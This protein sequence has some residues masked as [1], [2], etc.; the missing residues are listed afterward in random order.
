MANYIGPN[1]I[2][3]K[4][5]EYLCPP[6]FNHFYQNPPQ[7]VKGEMQYLYDEQGKKYLDFFAGVSVMN[8]GHCNPKILEA[9]IEQMKTLQ[10]TSIIYLTQPMVELAEKLATVLPGDLRRSFF[11][12]T[13]SEANETALLMAKMYTGKNEF[14]ALSNGLHG[15]TYMTMSTTAIPMWR[16]DPCLMENVHFAP[17]T[18]NLQ[19]GSEKAAE[20]SLAA[21][22]AIIKERGEDKIAALIMEPIQGNG[23][24]ITPPKNYFKK[25]KALLE[26]YH[27]LLIVDEVQTGF[28]RTGRMFA[29]E[30]YD[31]VPDIMTVAKALG[32]GMPISAACTNDKIAASFNKPS[33]STLGGNPVCAATA[34]AVLDYIQEN[35][36]MQRAK[37]LGNQL[38]EGLLTLKNKYPVI[39]DVRGMGLMVGVELRDGKGMALSQLTDDVLEALKDSGIIVG[40]NGLERNVLAFQ[41]PLV[42]TEDDIKFLL[43]QLDII[44]Y[45]FLKNS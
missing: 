39:T 43:Q 33:A 7:I 8:C 27:I 25:L 40:K 44:L 6:S 23:G 35:N 45:S 28:A 16:I 20:K 26:K 2:I 19:E 34:M 41:P 18:W 1:K 38:I 30:H 14:I 22:E 31:I 12:C 17:T 37:V 13:G 11:C 42:I 15:R 10:H 3:E 36:L 32:N 9:T 24:I 4:K 29:I 21:I 5:K